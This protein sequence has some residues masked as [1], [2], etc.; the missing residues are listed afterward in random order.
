MG[1][2]NPDLPIFGPNSGVPLLD[3][4]NVT[5]F[6]NNGSF[7]PGVSSGNMAVA[8]G[9]NWVPYYSFIL[10]VSINIRQILSYVGTVQA[11]QHFSTG[12][13]SADGQTLLIDMTPQDYNVGGFHRKIIPVV[14][15]AAGAYKWAWTQDTTAAGL[16]AYNNL[17]ASSSTIVL[18]DPAT[19]GMFISGFG[20]V[21]SVGGQM[22]ANLGTLNG[23]AGAAP[24][25]TQPFYQFVS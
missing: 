15:L 17:N 14:T 7:S 9:A 11:G 25:S 2:Y 20:S 13:Y 8:G 21:D 18:L 4:P 12:I 10:P 6:W 23:H 3:I 16:I 22:P 19:T 1:A 24:Q 5:A